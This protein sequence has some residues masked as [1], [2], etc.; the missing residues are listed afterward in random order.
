M[1][2]SVSRWKSS[3]SSTRWVARQSQDPYVKLRSQPSKSPSSDTNTTPAYR[4]RS[5]FK[6]LSLADRHRILLSPPK[7]FDHD[8]T[9]VDL[10]A[11]PGG[12]S[13]VASHLLGGRGR[14]FALDILDMTPIPGVDVIKG[15]FLSQDVQERLR[16]RIKAYRPRTFGLDGESGY[17]DQENQGVNTVLSDMMVAMSGVRVRDVQASL[18]LVTAATTFAMGVLRRAGDDEAVMEVRGRKVFP[19]GN[20]VSVFILRWKV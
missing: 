9:V 1:R 16:E 12:W 5:S 14:V 8:K 4:S 13:Q 18:D 2:A 17:E 10:G 6:L 7:E 15:D 19:G 20:L 11:A 3:P